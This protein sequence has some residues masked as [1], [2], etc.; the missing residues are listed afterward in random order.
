MAGNRGLYEA[1]HDIVDAVYLRAKTIRQRVLVP[2]A[3]SGMFGLYEV[4]MIAAML[5]APKW[6]RLR[7]QA[8]P[9]RNEQQQ[10]HALIETP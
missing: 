6:L 1:D 2:H 10:R 3:R 8:C 9:G 7:Q 5:A 4:R